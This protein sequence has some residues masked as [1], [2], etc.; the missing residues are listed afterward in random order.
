MDWLFGRQP[1]YSAYYPYAAPVTTAPVS[2][3]PISANPIS[4]SPAYVP[5]NSG[6]VQAQRPAYGY[7]TTAT[8]QSFDNPSVYTGL[9]VNSSAMA[10]QRLPVTSTA[11]VTSYNVPM[12]QSAPVESYRLPIQTYQSYSPATS[13]PI[14]STL[15]GN[16]TVN[17]IVSSSLYQSNYPQA[18]Y[19]SAIAPTGYAAPTTYGNVAPVLPLQ[20]RPRWTFGS[21]LRRFFN[22]LLGRDTNYV[23]SYYRAPITYYRPL[24]SVDPSTGTTV[25]VQQPCS[26]YVQ[27]LQR[28][29]YN[30]FAPAA[31]AP[32]I[33]GPSTFSP[34]SCSPSML[35]SSLPPTATPGTF[36][37]SGGIGQVGGEFAP[38]TSGVSPIPSTS[39][40][41]YGGSPNTAPLTGSGSMAPEDQQPVPRPELKVESGRPELAPAP[42]NNPARQRDADD[43]LYPYGTPGNAPAQRDTSGADDDGP[44]IRLDPPVSRFQQSPNGQVLGSTPPSLSA[45]QP[46]VGISNDPS[47]TYSTLR[48]IGVPDRDRTMSAPPFTGPSANARHPQDAA[49][50]TTN[51]FD[52][53]RNSQLSP[54]QLPP[55]TT[56]SPDASDLFRD[57]ERSA[58]FETT[59]RL[60]VPVREA[61]AR[62]R[63]ARPEPVRQVAA[64]NETTVQPV[65]KPAPKRDTSGWLPAE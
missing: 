9:P 6:V 35:G 39:P 62:T 53:E 30:S 24:N 29:P 61:T 36:A 43:D 63:Q 60:S 25:T 55:A 13:V 41:G 26:S 21:G 28:V 17:P 44:A 12:P 51:P 48:P 50:P 31:S 5:A 22:S 23:S 16:A 10:V 38:G 45:V 56:R 11:P 18:G 3:S 20:P 42:D 32:I 37:P 52:R 19:S 65:T 15:R 27:Q 58:R 7:G 46:N 4:A 47:Q 40:N 8:V 14:E 1:T 59:T 33:T 57:S 49:P 54:P 64:W 2:A 34:S